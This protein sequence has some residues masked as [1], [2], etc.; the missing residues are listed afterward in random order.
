MF[1][2]EIRKIMYTRVTPQFYCIKVGFEQSCMISDL[3]LICIN[4]L[5]QQKREKS[6]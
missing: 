6:P 3:V 2:G 1:R 4:V 5:N